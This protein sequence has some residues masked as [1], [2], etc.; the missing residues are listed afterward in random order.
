M[1]IGI[2][3]IWTVLLSI[4]AL[5]DFDARTRELIVGITVNINL[6]FFYGAPLSTIATVVKERNSASI[7]LWTM[8]TNTMNDAFWTA[9][10]IA[11]L[12]AFIYVP[13]GIG[14]LLLGVV[15]IVLI[16]LF[17]RKHHHSEEL[18]IDDNVS[19]V[20]MLATREMNVDRIDEGKEQAH[21]KTNQ[22]TTSDGSN[23]VS[24]PAERT[25]EGV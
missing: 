14:T 22:Y 5:V 24:P 19:S 21:D 12:Y 2:V 4:I 11:V 16:V 15:Q 23:T 3:T 7:H 13:N 10:G 6:F 18:Q 8:T 25:Q 9:N 20:N 17:P 1:V